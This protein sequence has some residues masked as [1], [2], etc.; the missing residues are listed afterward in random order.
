[1]K[2]AA[3]VAIFGLELRKNSI[4]FRVVAARVTA[5]ALA[6]L[7]RCERGKGRCVIDRPFRTVRIG[8]RAMHLVHLFSKP[9]ARITNPAV[10]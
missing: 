4:P 10:S 2:H 9:S 6:T 8:W 1:M 5:A 7:V 3:H